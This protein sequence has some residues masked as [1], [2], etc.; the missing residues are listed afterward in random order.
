MAATTP[1]PICPPVWQYA[2][3]MGDD[4]R[5]SLAGLEKIGWYHYN[6]KDE[7]VMNELATYLEGVAQGIRMRVEGLTGWEKPAP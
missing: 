3:I 4:I 7:A 1:L 5:G 2:L 6:Q